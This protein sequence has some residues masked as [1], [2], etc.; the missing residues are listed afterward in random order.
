MAQDVHRRPMPSLSEAI[1]KPF[2][3]VVARSSRILAVMKGR[4]ITRREPVQHKMYITDLYHSSTGFYTT[5]IVL[6][7]PSIPT[8]PGVRPLNDPAFRQ[9]RKAFRAL[10][11]RLDLDAPPGTMLGH[12][13]IQ[14]VV[15]ILLIRKDRDETR[16][17]G[18]Q[19]LLPD[20]GLCCIAHKPFNV[21]VRL[22][23]CSMR[24]Y[25]FFCQFL[26]L[27]TT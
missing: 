11:T 17:V 7:V 27:Y 4:A 1:R 12:P 13:G 2:R 18:L 22:M 23:L 15:V 24:K 3:L 8:M 10:W 6:T 14:S 9:R 5:L 19:A 21:V 16:K 26:F 25:L 20:N